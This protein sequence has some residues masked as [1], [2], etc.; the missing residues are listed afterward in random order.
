MHYLPASLKQNSGLCSA[1][2][3]RAGDAGGHQQDGAGSPRGSSG[4][5]AGRAGGDRAFR[6]Q[7]EWRGLPRGGR[8]ATLLPWPRARTCPSGKLTAATGEDGG[9]PQNTDFSSNAGGRREGGEGEE[10]HQRQ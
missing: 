5:A 9:R 7:P 2:L 4:A 8:G 10:E 6:Q 1:E 3:F